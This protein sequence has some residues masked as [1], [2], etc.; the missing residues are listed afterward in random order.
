MIY[1]NSESCR[2]ISLYFSFDSKFD[3]ASNQNYSCLGFPSIRKHVT[4]WDEAWTEIKNDTVSALVVPSWRT[5][6][7]EFNTED[8]LLAF[9]SEASSKQIKIISCEDKAE[10]DSSSV[11]SVLMVVQIYRT[12]SFEERS[13][14]VRK[15]L[16]LA[17]EMGQTLG[18]PLKVDVQKVK[19]LRREGF[20][21]QR[22]AES[23]GVSVGSVHR[24]LTD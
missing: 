13:S 24:A 6:F 4:S 1:S 2:N 9:L 18:R 20:T 5:L 14:N 11:S 22:I 23:L 12:N 17:K 3:R 8:D 10:I 15:G 19:D 16:K 21:I 7:E